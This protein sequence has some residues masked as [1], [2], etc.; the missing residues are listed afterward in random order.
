MA[1]INGTTGA[2]SLVGTSGNDTINGYGGGDTIDGGAGTDTVDYSGTQSQYTVYSDTHGG[3]YIETNASGLNFSLFD[4]IVNIERLQFSDVLVAPSSL[5][6]LI[7][8]AAGPTTITG[9]SGND[10]LVNGGGG[11]DTIDGGA[12]TN[13]LIYSGTLSQYTIYANGSTGFY[14]QTD[15]LGSSTSLYDQVINVQTLQFSDTSVTLMRGGTGLGAAVHGSTNNDYISDG[16]GGGD[17]IDGGGGSNALLFTGPESQYVVYSDQTGGYYIENTTNGFVPSKFDHVVDIQTFQFSDVSATPQSRTIGILALGGVT[18]KGTPANDVFIDDGLD[19]VTG[20]GRST[21]DGGAGFNTVVYDQSESAYTVYADGAGGYYVETNAKGFVFDHLINIQELQFSGA[22]ATPQSLAVGIMIPTGSGSLTAGAGNDVIYNVGGGGDTV[23]GGGGTNTLVYSGNHS[24]YSVFSDGAGGYYVSYVGLGG[25]AAGSIALAS[26]FSKF[27]H[28]ANIQTLQFS[29]QSG[30]I[31]SYMAGQVF[32][33]TTAGQ[34]LNGTSGSD[35]YYVTDPTVVVNESLGAGG[36]TDTVY[37]TLSS[38]T[39]PTNAE[40]LVFVGTG[41]FTGTGNSGNNTLIAG[42][43]PNETLDGGGGTGDVFY[44]SYSN[45]VIDAPTTTTSDQVYSTANFILP[46]NINYL[47]LTGANL[48]GIANSG[49]DTIIGDSYNQVFVAGSG[50]D[51]FTGGGGADVFVFGAG[52]GADVITDFNTSTNFVRLLSGTGFTTWAGVQAEMAQSGANVVL[53]ISAGNTVT[54]ENTTLSNFS[55]ANF[56]LPLDLSNLTLAFDDEFNSLSLSNGQTGTWATTYGYGGV[57]ALTSRTIPSN[58]EQQIYVDSNYAGAGGGATTSLGIN[59]FSIT[60]GVLSITAQATPS[61]DLGL[62]FNRPYTS[63]ML[64]TLPSF[65]EKYGY[66]EM[67]AELPS[68]AADWPAFWL[69]P[70]NASSKTELDILEYKST[71][72]NVSYGTEHDNG[73]SQGVQIYIPGATSGFHTY[74]L[75]WDPTHLTWY[76]DG[77]EVAQMATPSDMNQQMYIL[78]DYAIG[79]FSGTPDTTTTTSAFQIDYVKAWSINGVSVVAPAP[80]NDTIAGSVGTSGFNLAAGTE[81]NINGYNGTD[82]VVYSGASTSYTVYKDGFGGYIV[83]ADSTLLTKGVDH[84]TNVENI[85]F[86]DHTYD[87]TDSSVAGS[88]APN[89][90]IVGTS[91]GGYAGN[92]ILAVISNNST[93]IGGGGNDTILGGAG[94]Q[95]SSIDGGG[96]TNTLIYGQKPTAYSDGASGY[97]I[98]TVNNFA[99]LDHVVNV[100]S[101]L[102]NTTSEPLTG[103]GGVIK[104][105]PG[106]ASLTGGANNDLIIDGGGGGG[107]IDGGG[108]TANILAYSGAQAAYT[109]FSDG[110]GGYYVETN[111]LGLAPNLVD[112]AVNIQQLQFSTAVAPAAPVTTATLVIGAVGPASLTGGSGN[113]VLLNA[114]G[115]GDTIDGGAG[116]NTLAYTGLESAYTVYAD[117]SGGYYVETNALGANAGLFDHLVNIQTL[118]F[119]DYSVTPGSASIGTLII[120]GAGPV[121]L[122][123]GAGNDFLVNGGGGGDTIDGGGGTNTLIYSGAENQYTVYS[124]GGSGYYVETNALASSSASFDHLV[125]IQTLQ[126]SDATTSI[127]SLV[128]GQVYHLASGAVS[129]TGT[130]YADALISGSGV[131]TMIGGAGNDTYYVNNYSD[132]V[133]EAS[134]GGNDT[135][136]VNAAHWNATPGSYIEKVVALGTGAINLTGNALPMELDGN[137]GNNVLDDGGAADTLVGGAGGDTYMVANAATVIIEAAGGGADTIKTTLSSYTLPANVENLTYTGTGNFYGVGGSVTGTLTGGVGN[138]TLVSGSAQEILVG[139]GGTD[140]FYVNNSSDVVSATAGGNS[141]EFTSLSTLKAATNIVALTYTGSGGFTGFANSTGTFITGGGGNDLLEGDVGADTL[142]GAGGTDTLVG[143]SGADQFRFNAPGIGVDTI[144][145]FVSGTDHIAVVGTGF[146]L[147]SLSGVTFLISASPTPLNDGNPELL[148]NTTTGALSFDVDGG[149]THVVQFASLSGHPSVSSSDF[150][151]V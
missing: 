118:E 1:T 90:Y 39:L 44:V 32:L 12:G 138:D 107:F 81:N 102:W 133:T 52:G 131:D 125:N 136:Y 40:A 46:N 113:D 132:V 33:G 148:Y 96:G 74:G 86:S 98:E 64:T 45:T 24:Q 87:L 51:T 79:P 78:L 147:T 122:T 97:Y 116:A 69:L 127:T 54:F 35:I 99:V 124:D 88:L 57:D 95:N 103:L 38:Y 21:I 135:V 151:L 56:Q 72:P 126:F 123:G 16:G 140:T 84:L 134:G 49:A 66:F 108:G 111:A 19:D 100:Q 149:S 31:S 83:T 47:K 110:S 4:H 85:Q 93:L 13:T 36:G 34:T 106:Q 60:G 27:D 105:L 142:D 150:M 115:G 5:T 62:L 114:G 65:S 20:G 30:A 42:S 50:N 145:D 43:G 82:T 143:G 89:Y 3:F 2:D 77:A 104:G 137:S 120:G 94:G 67:S 76:V 61:A 141:V 75:L 101:L 48:T 92:N 129:Q 28:L 14:V 10:L 130:G 37:T 139:G 8:G 119:A 17:V 121:S 25:H 117:Q 11:G 55:A 29:D 68:G 23:D 109:V 7:F 112:H 41:S 63:G 15:A 146:G 18:T 144:N 58:S 59:P 91:P 128:Q 73:A 22:S 70:V 9:T 53:T 71:N 6:S 80:S 26:S